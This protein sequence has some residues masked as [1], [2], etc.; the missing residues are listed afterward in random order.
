MVEH[1][2]L[3]GAGVAEVVHDRGRVLVQEIGLVVES[4]ELDGRSGSAPTI[5]GPR[6]TV[7]RRA[8]GQLRVQNVD[9]RVVVGL[10]LL[11]VG[12][13]ILLLIQKVVRVL[14]LLD[15]ATLRRLIALKVA[16]HRLSG[17]LDGVAELLLLLPPRIHLDVLFHVL[18]ESNHPVLLL[19]LKEFTRVGDLSRDVQVLLAEFLQHATL[20]V[21]LRRQRVILLDHAE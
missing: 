12:Q 10:R 16:V 13:L 4:V 5:A 19:L 9:P 18:R 15:K 11:C 2:V 3:V 7:H 8:F 1:F 14:Q 20:P 6:P 17:L 21:V